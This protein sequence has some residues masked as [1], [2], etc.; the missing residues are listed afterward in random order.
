MDRFSWD[1]GMGSPWYIRF[2]R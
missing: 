1:F 2:W